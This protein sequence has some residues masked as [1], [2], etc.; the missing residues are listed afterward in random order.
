[1]DTDPLVARLTAAV[2]ST[3]VLTDP[4]VIAAYTTD[5][6][7]RFGGPAR[8]VVRPADTS[9]VAE[10][11]RACGEEGAAIVPQGGNTGLVGGGVPHG[12]EVV[13]SLR[14]LTSIGPVDTA[15]MQVTAGAGV[16]LADLQRRV[17]AEGL[18][19]GVDLAARDSATIGGMVATNAGGERVLRYGTTRANVAGVEAVLADGGTIDRLAGLPKDNVGYDL[20]GLLVG[21]EGTLGIITRARLRLVPLRAGRATALLALDSMDAAVSAVTALRAL[22][23]LELAE[24]FFANGLDLVC[25]TSGLPAPFARSHPVYLLVECAASHDPT[26]ELFEVIEKLTAIEEAAVA[27]DRADRQ[28]MS[29]YREGHT[30]AIN[31]A[32]VPLK[33]DIAVPLAALPDFVRDLQA[34][35]AGVATSYLFGHLAE[36]NLHVNLLGA[37]DRAE[38]LTEAVLRRVAA[39]QGSISAEHGVGRAKARWLGLSRSPAEIAAMR[40]VKHALDP[41]GLLNPGVILPSDP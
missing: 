24:F 23:S 3:H 6:T 40:A 8:L 28:R 21:S 29:A 14:R 18:D 2:G 25:R 39:V 27:V 32:G 1:M 10:I 11:V 41:H 36:G 12:D 37:G 5:F 38:E 34:L 4:Q 31:T 33:L 19:F 17:R 7:G 22:P 9:E 26:D 20:P 15:A 35:V 16:S 13:L 30:E